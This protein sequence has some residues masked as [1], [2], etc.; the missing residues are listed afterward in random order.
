[1]FNTIQAV[2]RGLRPGQAQTVSN[3]TVVPLLSDITDDTIASPEVLE[4]ETRDYGTVVAYNT[5]TD[6]K[7]GHHSLS[8]VTMDSAHFSLWGSKPSSSSVNA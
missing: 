2:M 1:M 3:M 6:S 8:E 4:L 7:T 5:G